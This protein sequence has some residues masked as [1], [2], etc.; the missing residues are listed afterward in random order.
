MYQEDAAT[1]PESG[2]SDHRSRL[3]PRLLCAVQFAWPGL[4]LFLLI[5]FT[6]GSILHYAELRQPCTLAQEVCLQTL[7]LGPANLQGIPSPEAALRFFAAFFTIE[8]VSIRLILWIIAGLIFW[9]RRDHWLALLVAFWLLTYAP[10]FAEFAAAQRWPWLF[11]PIT[12]VQLIGQV[13]AI[14][15]FFVF[16]NGRFTPQWMRWPAA[17]FLIFAVFMVLIPKFSTAF[18]QTIWSGLAL[19]LQFGFILFSQVYRYRRESSLV[20]RLQMKWIIFGIVVSSLILIANRLWIGA[21]WDLNQP[22]STKFYLQMLL[23]AAHTIIIPIAIGVA[24]LRYRLFDIDLVLNRTLVFG[25]LAALVAGTY[26][27]VA[28]GVNLLVGSQGLNF[29]PSLIA[30]SLIALSF[31]PLYYRLQRW[32]NRLIYGERDEPY[33]VLARLGQ[34]LESVIDSGEAFSLTV[35]TV[36]QALKLPYVAIT[37]QPKKP[38]LPQAKIATALYSASS[39]DV[40]KTQTICFPLVYANETIGELLVAPRSSV[41]SLSKVDRHLLNTLAQQISVAAHATLLAEELQSARLQIVDAREETRRRLGSDLHDGIGHQLTGLARKTER[42][43]QQVAHQP[44]GEDPA[45]IS[46][47][48]NEI[49]WQLNATILQVRALAHQLHPPE[50]ETLGLIEALREQVQT[51]PGLSIRVEAPGDLPELPAAVETAA[52][53]IALEALTN[54]EKHASAKTC[55][56]RFSIEEP[57]MPHLP[58]LLL[59]I[60]DDGVGVSN[61]DSGGLGLL[62][63]QGRAAEVGGTCQV[64]S[65]TAGATM[66]AVGTTVRICLPFHQISRGG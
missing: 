65:G 10:P 48:L 20:E 14:L 43:A 46:E 6:I 32:I 33:Q 25:T 29:L 63:M 4:A 57:S 27:L 2:R 42:I 44:A 60:S 11:V 45:P 9:K 15:F 40:S 62:S 19:A 35:E 13:S 49:T 39:Y 21:D 36:A 31:L 58:V 50:L 22:I 5:L 66:A 1:I 12:A 3:I 54:I 8:Q 47:A 28:S 53:Y 64:T 7:Q 16:P 30:A 52:Y 17:C 59:E 24:I 61:A 34:K 41:E 23:F 55:L 56:I 18:N 26:A 38:I 51:H 37:L